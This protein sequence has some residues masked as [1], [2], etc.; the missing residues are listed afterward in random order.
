MAHLKRSLLGLKNKKGAGR[1]LESP[2][3][4]FNRRVPFQH[5]DQVKLLVDNMLVDP[6][7]IAV[8]LQATRDHIAQR[9]AHSRQT[10]GTD[11]N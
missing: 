1:P 9:L 8:L 3:M 5:I 2:K 10:Q 11:G 7:L 6:G 4:Q